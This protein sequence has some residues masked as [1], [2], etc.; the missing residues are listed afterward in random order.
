MP[1]T[2][3]CPSCGYTN[4]G[5][6]QVRCIMCERLLRNPSVEIP[7]SVDGTWNCSR[8]TF[9]NGPGER[10]CSVC[11]APRGGIPRR[12]G[13]TALLSCCRTLARGGTTSGFL[14]GMLIGSLVG[15]NLGLLAAAT[16]GDPSLVFLWALG[17][18]LLGGPLGFVSPCAPR[19]QPNLRED[20]IDTQ[21][22]PRPA[23]LSMT[24]FSNNEQ[25]QTQQ[26][27]QSRER[28]ALPVVAMPPITG[29]RPGFPPPPLLMRHWSSQ[30]QQRDRSM[31]QLQRQINQQEAQTQPARPRVMA[32]LPTHAV[33]AQEV[34]S[35]PEDCKTCTIC[36]EEFRV[37]DEQR[38]LPCF[39]RF[40]KACID[41]WL[42]Q[43]GTCPICKHRADEGASLTSSARGIR[44]FPLDFR[45]ESALAS[46]AR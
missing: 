7:A 17:C 4:Q 39:H 26:T 10:A 1:S 30:R 36:I 2:W 41:T 13:R 34:A 45:G 38:T 12:T 32:A 42:R 14:A 35:A 20:L 27:Q 22:Q 46:G 28:P 3:R 44:W 23:N 16:S 33:T 21:T 43:N 8:C 9:E 11:L 40:H 5:S 37:G 25:Q 6:S 29:A 15:A 31:Q 24:N 19:R 18:G